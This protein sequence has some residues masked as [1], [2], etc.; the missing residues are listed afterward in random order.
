MRPGWCS[1]RVGFAEGFDF[2]DEADQSEHAPPDAPSSKFVKVSS[3]RVRPVKIEQIRAARL[4]LI[5]LHHPREGGGRRDPVQTAP[6]P[7]FPSQLISRGQPTGAREQ[8][9]TVA[10]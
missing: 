6:D 10:Q 7:N 3:R 1:A 4:G 9:F 8:G 2:L 5:L